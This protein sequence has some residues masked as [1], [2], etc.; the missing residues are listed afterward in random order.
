MPLLGRKMTTVLETKRALAT[1]AMGS[2]K[3]IRISRLTTSRVRALDPRGRGI[4]MVSFTGHIVRE[5]GPYCCK[6]QRRA[7]RIEG[8]LCSLCREESRDRQA[9]GAIV[10]IVICAALLIMGFAA[11]HGEWM[12]MN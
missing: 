2:R 11:A 5:N 4:E 8:S 9:M 10:V 1:G 12:R 7:V 3:T 6:C